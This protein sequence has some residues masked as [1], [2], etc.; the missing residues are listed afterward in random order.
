MDLGED[1]EVSNLLDLVE[2]FYSS[3]RP[4]IT[5]QINANQEVSNI[6][7]GMVIQKSTPNLLALLETHARGDSPA[8]LVDPRPAAPLSSRPFLLN[9]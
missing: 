2:H 9:P 8:I 6:P 1:F 3:S 4:Q 5:A 7:E